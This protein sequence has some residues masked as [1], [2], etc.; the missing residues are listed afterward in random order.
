VGARVR[1]Q[2]ARE[3]RCGLGLPRLGLGF[4]DWPSEVLRAKPLPRA[5]RAWDFQR[6]TRLT[7]LPS[8]RHVAHDSRARLGF[9]LSQDPQ[10]FPK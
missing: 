5:P 9:P 1:G 7:R 4:R 6:T 2:V 3:P 8:L 10:N